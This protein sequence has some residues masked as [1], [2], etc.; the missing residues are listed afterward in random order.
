MVLLW[1]ALA[2][3]AASAVHALE[4]QIDSAD[5]IRQASSTIAYDMMEVYVGNQT[6]GNPGNLPE[7]YY[8]W[9]AGGMFMHMVWYYYCASMILG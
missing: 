2:S 8:W 6:G 5:S 9:E 4:L 1:V 3:L 7:P